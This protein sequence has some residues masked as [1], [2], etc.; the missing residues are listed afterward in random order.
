[1]SA[2]DELAAAEVLLRHGADI[3]STVTHAHG[4]ALDA[5]TGTDTRRDVLATW[6]RDLGARSSDDSGT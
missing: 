4:T 5:A 1:M 3:N 2:A 6:L